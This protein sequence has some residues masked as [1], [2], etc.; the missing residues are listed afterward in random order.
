MSRRAFTLVELLV[1][2]SIIGLMS[3]IAAVSLNSARVN[4]RN[5]QRKANLVQL[6]KALELYYADYGSFPSTGGLGWSVVSGGGNYVVKESTG[7]NGWIPNLAPAYIAVLPTDPN[8]NTVNLSNMRS[9]CR[10]VASWNGYVYRSNGTDYKI[11]ANCL[12]E[13]AMSLT[14]QFADPAPWSG[15]IRGAYR[16]A[17][18]TPGAADWS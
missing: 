11:F 18:W 16:W 5:A 17:V 1:V 4:A 10:T 7:A 14:D 6:S 9:E 12:P 8:T 13:G 15:T 3:A 2:I